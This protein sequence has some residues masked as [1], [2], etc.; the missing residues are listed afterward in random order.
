L[1]QAALDQTALAQPV[2]RPPTQARRDR[3][4]NAAERAFAR[5]GFHRTTM[6][7]VAVEC[8]MSPGNL[9]RYFEGKDALV[10]G[11]VERDRERF[12]A[13][14][15]AIVNDEKPANA[16]IR[17]GRHHLVEEPREKAVLVTEIWAE[18]CRNPRIAEVCAT[19]DRSIKDCLT[20]FIIH[21]RSVNGANSPHAPEEVAGLIIALS[22]GLL[23]MRATNP[24]FEANSAFG[25]AVP[26]VF[27]LIGA[28][29]SEIT[30]AL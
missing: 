17:L 22:D 9:Y 3:I 13:D 12:N 6:Q 19:M 14:V 8:E 21:W 28:S 7:D 18:S 2:E 25:L 4:L 1:P 15:Q 27:S 26:T 16:F 5:Q 24:D 20:S 23:R 30:E 11:I 10:A 29:P